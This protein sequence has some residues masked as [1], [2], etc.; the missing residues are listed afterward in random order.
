MN[1]NRYLEATGLIPAGET[2]TYSELALLSGKPQAARAAGRAISACPADAKVPWH[3]VVSADGSLSREESRAEEQLARLRRENAR[4]R[5]K[6]SVEAFARRIG[7]GWIGRLKD[8]RFT[9]ASDV[10]IAEWPAEGIEALASA[11]TARARGFAPL[12]AQEPEPDRRSKRRRA[13]ESGSTSLPGAPPVSR[14]AK[15]S[16]SHEGPMAQS[17][18]QAR[19]RSDSESRPMSR[20]SRAP[21]ARAREDIR[22]RLGVLDW[23]RAL[24]ELGATGCFVAPDLLTE[25]ECATLR[26]T[27]DDDARFERTI[28][29]RPRGYGIGTYRYFK[30]PLPRPARE[31]REELYTR[32]LDLARQAPS[33][34]EYPSSLAEFWERCRAQ[35]QKRSSSILLHYTEGGLNHPHRDIYGKQWF[36]YQALLVLSRRGFDFDGGEFLLHEK[37]SRGRSSQRAFPLDQG[38][39]CVFASRGH[40]GSSGPKQRWIELEHGMSPVTRGERF[41]LGIVLHLAE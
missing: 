5:A 35:G 13:A 3:R 19:G 17:P 16:R 33:A 27:F 34:P 14:P 21:R 4:P 38:D 15:R 41:G 6:E 12:D 23:P 29:M 28:D 36:P 24:E 10:R 2:R 30:E 25:A 11:D 7:A 39:L 20:G 31:V 9:A 37:D 8:R 26:A 22:T 40:G 18:T 32:L 1:T